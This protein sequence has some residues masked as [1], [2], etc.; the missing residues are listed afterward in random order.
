MEKVSIIMPT[1]NS[2]KTLK[3]TIKSILRQTYKNIEL[4]IV[5]DG[6]TDD[7]KRICMEFCNIDN[8]IIY[9]YM[10]KTGVSKARNIAIEK[11]TGKYIMFIDSDDEYLENTVEIMIN[12]IEEG[13]DLVCASFFYKYGNKLVK[14]RINTISTDANTILECINFLHKSNT[15]KTLWN[16]IFRKD[17]I[18]KNKIRMDEK[19]NNGEDYKFTIDYLKFCNA[20]KVIQDYIYIY[21]VHNYGLSSNLK[22]YTLDIRLYLLEHHRNMYKQRNF[23]LQYIDKQYIVAFYAYIFNQLYIGKKLS[24]KEKYEI[25]SNSLENSII[26]KRIIENKSQYGIK[27]NILAKIIKS[28]NKKIILILSYVILFIRTKKGDYKY[29]KI[30][31]NQKNY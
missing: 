25:I 12:N 23:S 24:K 8:R 15:L 29:K 4:I 16:K 18:S 6:S 1:F 3:A 13:Y 7:T 22:D 28:E 19:L 2:E 14:N 11:A 9:I 20:I 26:R 31:K 30:Q 10:K 21:N 5:D 17:I 27:F